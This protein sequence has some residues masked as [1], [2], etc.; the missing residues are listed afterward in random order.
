MHI[1]LIF[2]LDYHDGILRISSGFF[3]IDETKGNF[4]AAHKHLEH[5]RKASRGRT[6]WRYDNGL[7]WHQENCRN[8]TRI[9]IKMSRSEENIVTRKKLL[10]EACKS[11]TESKLGK[12][13]F[14]K[15]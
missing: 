9:L 3:K 4:Q 14:L 15:F 5:S 13:A 1:Y 8:F 11:A 6:N 12:N 7:T 2:T 10:V